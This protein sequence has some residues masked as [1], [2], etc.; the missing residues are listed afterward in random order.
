MDFKK[1]NGSATGVFT[2]KLDVNGHENAET[3]EPTRRGPA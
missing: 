2:E 3:N 1:R